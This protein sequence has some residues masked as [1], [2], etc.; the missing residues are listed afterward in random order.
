MRLLRLVVVL[1]ALIVGLLAAPA[2]AEE[3]PIITNVTPPTITGSAQFEKTLT[4]QP[5]EWSP[6][7]VELSYE[8][9]RDGVKVGTSS[10]TYKLAKTA[11]IGKVFTVR[12]TASR[13]GS[14]PTTVVSAPTAAVK[15]A[16]V[17]NVKRP[18]FSGNARFK[19]TLKAS[20]GKWSRGGLS[21]SYR[22]TR[23]DKPIGGATRRT[24]T[25]KPQDVGHRIRVQVTV[26]RSGFTSV[27]ARSKPKRVQHLRSVRR[28]VT[29]RVVTK[30]KISSSVSTFRKQAAETY[31]DPRG[32][33]GMGVAF[34][35]VKKGGDF[36]LVLAQATK[37]PS[38][39]SACSS[40]YS[41]RVG[42]YVIINQTRWQKATPAWNAKKGSSRNYRHMVVNHETGHWFGRGHVR[43]SGK[44]SLAPVMQQQS[45][46][47]GGCKINPW[48]K[49]N[50]LHSPRFGY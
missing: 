23:D 27:T 44:G 34:K 29:Y 31:A 10:P 39:S 18:T 33:R 2:S 9:L 20:A 48:P 47:L 41:C 26:R 40:A 36:T 32:W 12:V 1:S 50:E 22:W 30:G 8:W 17:T 14:T 43:C 4:A 46:G 38:Y 35:E 49:S 45:K 16:T 3:L 28:T 6:A 42:R 25:L 5:G 7:D 19:Q 37:V 11:D 24:Y 21:K 13:A 15:R